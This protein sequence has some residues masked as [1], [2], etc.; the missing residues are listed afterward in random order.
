MKR[1]RVR[2]LDKR[3]VL[4]AVPSQPFGRDR[5]TPR[6]RNREKRVPSKVHNQ[7]LNPQ[8]TLLPPARGGGHES[9]VITL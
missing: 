3:M 1:R 9:C 7:L 5:R 4:A 6:T 2:Q 8:M